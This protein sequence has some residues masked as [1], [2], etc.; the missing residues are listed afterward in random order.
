MIYKHLLKTFFLLMLFSSCSKDIS[1]NIPEKD[2]SMVINSTIAPWNLPNNPKGVSAI[3]NQSIHI[4]DSS[5]NTAL[6][7]AIVTIFE[8]ESLIDTLTYNDSLR[9][10]SLTKF[11]FPTLENTYTLKVKHPIYGIITTT[12]NIPS[13]IEI[14]DTVITPIVFIDEDNAPYNEIALT[15]KDDIN[16]TNYYEVVLSGAS[17]DFNSSENYYELSS[18]DKL[19]TREPYYP[20]LERFDI[21]KPK[22]LLFTDLGIEGEEYTL[23]FNYMPPLIIDRGNEIVPSHYVSIHLR[24]ITKEYYL[25]K[26][27]WIQQ[28]N[29]QVEDVLY[30]GAEPMNVYSNIENGYGVFAGFNFASATMR[31][32]EV[33]F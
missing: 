8:N 32:D 10:Y 27:S 18:H 28:L 25:F 12:T 30:G 19:I 14:I 7:D 4:S 6:P 1:I 23:K 26:T 29:N 31:V 11:W 33:D 17:F 24:N 13:K 20:K 2:Y 21:K 9:M 5:L 16:E 15:L 3:V 22:F